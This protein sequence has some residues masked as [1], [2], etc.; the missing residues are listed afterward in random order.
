MQWL[1]NKK[2]PFTSN[3][4][5]PELYKLV[6]MNKPLEKPSKIDSI[7][8]NHGHTVIRLPPYHPDLNP[9]E[10]IWAQLKHS[11]AKNNTTFD[12]K[13]IID[14]TRQ[15]CQSIEKQQW[16]SVCEH[17][18][19]I[20]DE[21]LEREGLIDEMQDR[22][23]INLDEDDDDDDD[24]D[25]LSSAESSSD[26]GSYISGVEAILDRE[27]SPDLENDTEFPVHSDFVYTSL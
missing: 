27:T 26:D 25:D 16:T 19:K 15:A 4:F 12:N 10:L 20:E 21:Y 11:V 9:I 3:M 23:V 5:K 18:I 1:S 14:L 17:V 24:D 22:L 6:K 2:I 7:L 8:G 13:N